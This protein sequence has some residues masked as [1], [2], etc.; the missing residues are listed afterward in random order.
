MSANPRPLAERFWEKV[1]KNGPVIYPD[2]GPCWMWNAATRNEEGYGIISDKGNNLV[3]SRVAYELQNSPIPDGMLVL[4]KCDNPSCVRGD[5]LYIGTQKE[6]I[7]DAFRRGR[8]GNKPHCKYGHP[9]DEQN[10]RITR[11]GRECRE[12]GRLKSNANRRAKGIPTREEWEAKRR[13]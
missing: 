8:K 1:D 10:T 3:A 9:F 11:R 6:N 4:H 13:R 2:L 5:H 7:Q 12:C